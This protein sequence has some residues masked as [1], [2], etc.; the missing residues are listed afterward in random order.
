VFDCLSNFWIVVCQNKLECIG[1]GPIAMSP[2]AIHTP[3]VRLGLLCGRHSNG[4]WAKYCTY[5]LRCI[6]AA[7]SVA[8]GASSL[9]SD[10]SSEWS[11]YVV[12]CERT[13]G[14]TDGHT[15]LNTMSP[16]Y[17][18]A[19]DNYSHG[20]QISIFNTDLLSQIIIHDIPVC[21]KVHKTDWTHLWLRS[22]SQ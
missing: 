12:Q 1:I 10:N 4:R 22:G 7:G 11:S 18:S 14:R 20:H 2:A 19:G 5:D 6:T 9:R 21:H 17:A 3:T 15:R 13:D 8:A 16:R